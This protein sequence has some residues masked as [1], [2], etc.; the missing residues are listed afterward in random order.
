VFLF[1]SK[2]LPLFIYPLGLSCILLAVALFLSYKRSRWAYVPIALALLILF[3]AG[4]VRVSDRLVK[5]LEWQYLPRNPMP[6][7]E[8]IVILGGATRNIDAPRIMPDL[9]ERGDRL[10][11]GGKL[12]QDDLAPL[13]ILSG[14]RIQW[15]GGVE[16]EAQDM[17]TILQLMGIPSEAMILEPNALNTYQNAIYT[18]KILQERGIKKI[19]LVTSAIH[20]LRSLAIFRK[21]GMEA[22]PAPT[23]FL[24]SEGNFR[25]V[26][27][28]LE[29]RILSWFPDSES[30]ERTTLALREYIGIVIY[31]LRGWL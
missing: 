19:L 17:A 4:N 8:A 11:Y 16:S 28:S 25:A 22:I 12:Y 24:V 29:S 23:D 10:L 31:R 7:A 9:S 15:F 14:G 21:Q 6:E 20:M 3:V 30:L 13:I 2:L 18:Q 5:S 27:Y 26:N 1:L